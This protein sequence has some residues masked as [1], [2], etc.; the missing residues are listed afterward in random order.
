ML[1][2][3]QV[4]DEMV[5]GPG[6]TLSNS[7]LLFNERPLSPVLRQVSKMPYF[8]VQSAPLRTKSQA[9]AAC[10]RARTH[11]QTRS[12]STHRKQL[13]DGDLGSFNSKT[14]L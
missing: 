12:A 10:M 4:A 3:P 2:A 13:L 7:V 9:A 14:H 6:V 8:A 5:L 1:L 11:T